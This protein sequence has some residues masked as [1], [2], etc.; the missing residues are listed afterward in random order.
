MTRPPMMRQ[1]N[2]RHFCRWTGPRETIMQLLSQTPK[3]MSA[4]EMYAAIH[5]HYP[6]IGLTTIYR[7][8]DLLTRMGLIHKF[9]FGDG[10]SRYEFISDERKK[11]HHHLIC[12]NCGKIFDYS[13]F[14]EEELALVKKT[15]ERLANKYD[16]QIEGHNIEFL[17]LCKICQK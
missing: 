11:H 1:R 12:T 8:L 10:H 9:S 4:K 13:E 2:R 3:H 14:E 16:F 5:R 7:T 15:Q 17:G 6:G